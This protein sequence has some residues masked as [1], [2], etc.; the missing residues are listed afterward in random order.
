MRYHVYTEARHPLGPVAAGHSLHVY[1][2]AAGTVTSSIYAAASGGSPLANP[3]TVPAAGKVDFW[4]TVPEPYGDSGD[5]VLQP[6]PILVATPADIGAADPNSAN[7]FV[8]DQDFVNTLN[9]TRHSPGLTAEINFCAVEPFMD[10][11]V[12]AIADL[13]IDG[14]SFAICFAPDA[15]GAGG[16]DRLNIG[17]TAPNRLQF[18]GT[19][20]FVI[21]EPGSPFFLL[22]AQNTDLTDRVL[23]L[24]HPPNQT[25]SLI[26]VRDGY[27]AESL[28][29]DASGNLNIGGTKLTLSDGNDYWRIGVSP[30][31]VLGTT[32]VPVNY[33][34]NPSFELDTNA[35]GTPDNWV[36]ANCDTATPPTL[37]LV[38][39]RTGGLALRIQYT[40]VPADSGR[41][42]TLATVTPDRFRGGDPMTSSLYAKG[43]LSGAWAAMRAYG[44]GSD[45]VDFGTQQ[46]VFFS[47]DYARASFSGTCPTPTSQ[48]GAYLNFGSIDNGDTIDVTIDDF[49]IEKAASVGTYFDGSTA[50]HAWRVGANSSPSYEV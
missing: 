43:S 3:L 38:A 24:T 27:T 19:N 37:S 7:V 6:L 34:L 42:F 20:G 47:G 39:G 26:S 9:V 15:A 30:A 41:S 31:G 13:G 28:R 17:T 40:G 11:R 8:R 33:A 46:E 23:D 22:N 25:G 36:I 16:G 45:W 35:D 50:G 14:T 32:L 21:N 1:D 49:M 12:G 4:A 44:W 5:G 2:D 18:G 48:V 29:L 10:Q